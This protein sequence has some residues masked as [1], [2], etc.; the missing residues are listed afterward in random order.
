MKVPI[1][2]L[3]KQQNKKNF[4]ANS[5]KPIPQGFMV[6][7]DFSKMLDDK[8]AAHYEKLPDSHCPKSI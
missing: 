7:E 1:I 8:I 2:P 5:N 4:F 3:R 6:L